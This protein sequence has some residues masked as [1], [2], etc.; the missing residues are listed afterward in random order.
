[1]NIP[2]TEETFS[3]HSVEAIREAMGGCERYSR[4][5]LALRQELAMRKPDG[6]RMSL[7]EYALGSNDGSADLEAAYKF[8]QTQLAAESD[9][10]ACREN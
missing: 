4:K 6:S 3:Q 1:M 9:R 10:A 7:R 2:V 5:W 8:Q